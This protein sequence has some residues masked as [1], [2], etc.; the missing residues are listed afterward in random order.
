MNKMFS[1]DYAS[2]TEYVNKNKNVET[3]LFYKNFSIIFR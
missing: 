1:E 3:K 2:A